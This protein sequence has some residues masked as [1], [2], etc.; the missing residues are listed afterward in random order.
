MNKFQNNLL[1]IY[2]GILAIMIIFPPT[3]VTESP[4]VSRIGDITLAKQQGSGGF[5][6]I[7]SLGN[8][9]SNGHWDVTISLDASQLTIQVV[10]VSLIVS[11]LWLA[12]R[13]VNKK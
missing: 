10:I 13:S 9:T 8:Q 1:Y 11:A 4:S 3:I 7:G 5:K 12:S 6:F 2:A